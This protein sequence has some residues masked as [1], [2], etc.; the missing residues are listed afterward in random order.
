[1]TKSIIFDLDGTLW[2][3]GREVCQIW[4]DY[5][6]KEYDTNFQLSREE[7]NELMGKMNHEIGEILFPDLERAEQK[8]LMDGCGVA[9]VVYLEKHGAVLYDGVEETIRELSSRYDLYIVSNCQNGYVQAF[10][11]AHH[12]WTYFKDI[13]MEGR[14]GYPKAENI[15]LLMERNH[16]RPEETFYVGDTQGDLNSAHKAGIPFVHVTYGFGQVDHPDRSI[17][18]IRELL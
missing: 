10:L 18:D 7:L 11:T 17:D 3:S 13:E 16:M 8:R 6:R 2:D 9:E 4:N 15:V 12:M 5:F 1:M 14:T